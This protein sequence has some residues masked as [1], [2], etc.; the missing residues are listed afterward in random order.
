MSLKSLSIYSTLK[1]SEIFVSSS[2]QKF[3]VI[4]PITFCQDLPFHSQ[5]PSWRPSDDHRVHDQIELPQPTRTSFGR[6][7]QNQPHHDRFHINSRDRRQRIRA[8]ESSGRL[9]KVTPSDAPPQ[10]ATV[11]PPERRRSPNTDS[12]CAENPR[13][14][15]RRKF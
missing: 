6:L 5:F 9:S 12:D 7:R 13:N 1:Y 10:E 11:G 3:R 4:H 8:A 15:M 14:R 2:M